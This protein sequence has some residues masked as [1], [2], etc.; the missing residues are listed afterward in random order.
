MRASVVG[1]TRSTSIALLALALSACT[2]MKGVEVDGRQLIPADAGVVFGFELDPLRNSPLGPVLHTAMQSDPDARGMLESVPK[3]NVDLAGLKGMFAMKTDSDDMYMAVVES[4]G[5][6]TEDN[7]RCLESELAKATGKAQDGILIFETKGDVRVTPQQDGGYMVIL[8]KNTLVMMSRP[9]ETVVFDAIAKPEARN[10]TSP[11]AKAAAGIDPSTDLWFAV[12]LSDSDRAGMADIK[13]AETLQVVSATSD[14]SS[15]MKLDL[16]LDTKD[17]A[18]AS[19]LVTSLTEALAMA[20]PTLK[21]AGLPETLLDGVK[22]STAD[23]RVTAKMEI[24]K[25]VL[26][27]LITAMAPFFAGG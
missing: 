10:T 18:S 24:G 2:E 4:P 13:G 14:L 20:K 22:L 9:W 8:N 17:A 27:G 7:V 5:I 11:L 19:T 23:A 15:G 6:G 1:M 12:A 21:D 26:P 16:A 25:D 3:C